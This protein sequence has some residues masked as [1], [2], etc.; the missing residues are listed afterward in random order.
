MLYAREGQ[1]LE[2]AEIFFATEAAF[3]ELKQTTEIC[4]NV[5]FRRNASINEYMDYHWESA[6]PGDK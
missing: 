2:G 6:D 4:S 3:E 1:F 5:G